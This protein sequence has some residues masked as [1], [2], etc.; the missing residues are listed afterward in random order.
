MDIAKIILMACLSFL[1]LC[2][3]VAGLALATKWLGEDED[4]DGGGDQPAA[5]KPSPYG[6]DPQKDTSDW[7]KYET[8]KTRN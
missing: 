1:A 6:I 2:W 8:S 4:E 5:V 3:G 7:W